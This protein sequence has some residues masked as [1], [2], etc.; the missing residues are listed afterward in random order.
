MANKIDIQRKKTT[1]ELFIFNL[2]Q[3]IRFCYDKLPKS[4][5]KMI[6][7][8]QL[9]FGSLHEKRMSQKHLD[10]KIQP[11]NNINYFNTVINQSLVI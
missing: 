11:K 10:I 3:S 6:H 8:G 4:I 7:R 2:K 1:F 5:S 9:K